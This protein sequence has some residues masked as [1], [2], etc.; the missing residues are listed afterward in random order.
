MLNFSCCAK[1]LQKK[2][3]DTGQNTKLDIPIVAILYTP[4]CIPHGSV[5]NWRNPHGVCTE[6][7]ESAW[8]LHGVRTD[9]TES[10]QT[11][12]SPHRL[13]GIQVDSAQTTQVQVGI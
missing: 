8:N 12:R 2:R 7:T 3:F 10:A 1:Q 11:A 5:W 4:P 9:C 6:C 13:H